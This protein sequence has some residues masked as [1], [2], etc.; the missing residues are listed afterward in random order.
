MARCSRDASAGADRGVLAAVGIKLGSVVTPISFD[1]S[2]VA[3]CCCWYGF[4]SCIGFA[5]ICDA[6]EGVD[7]DDRNSGA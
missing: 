2:N 6:N 4:C 1:G 3:T 7:P 5:A